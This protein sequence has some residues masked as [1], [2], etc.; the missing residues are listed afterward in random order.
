VLQLAPGTV[1][2]PD[3][4]AFGKGPVDGRAT[5]YVCQGQ[6]CQAP[7]VEPADLAASLATA[8]LRAT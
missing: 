2:R 3:H 1:L 4:P 5:A 7:V 8:S 6:T